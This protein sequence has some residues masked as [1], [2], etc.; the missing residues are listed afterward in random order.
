ML[1]DLQRF[2]LTA[3]RD[4]ERDAA[5][6]RGLAD[7]R[8]ED[9]D[10]SSLVDDAE[11][12]AARLEQL[13]WPAPRHGGLMHVFVIEDVSE[14]TWRPDTANLFYAVALPNGETGQAATGITGT[15]QDVLT[16]LNGRVKA[17][18]LEEVTA[19]LRSEHGLRI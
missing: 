9:E 16:T 15:R 2:R 6:A 14:S 10:V 13:R 4:L 8:D 12:H 5:Y 18:G 19:E 3:A 17:L 1:T 11:E 7:D